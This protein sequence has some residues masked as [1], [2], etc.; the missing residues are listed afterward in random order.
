[1]NFTKHYGY[2]GKHSLLSASQNAWTNY[3]E[4]KFDIWMRG[5]LAAGRGTELHAFAAQ[6]IKLGIRMLD[7]GETLNSYVNDAIGFRMSPEVILH[8]SDNAFVTCDAIGFMINRETGKMKLRV[9]DLKTG[10]NHAS[11]RQ[12]EVYVAYFCLEYRVK[13]GE[14]EIE[15]R[16]YQNDEIKERIPELATIVQIMDTIV[17]FDRQA[18]LLREEMNG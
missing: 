16:I 11:F 12:L 5:K 18:D 14:I 7:N 13:P 4:E 8:Y 15:L 3:T 9:Y 1:M 10:I 6:A 17:A 2:E